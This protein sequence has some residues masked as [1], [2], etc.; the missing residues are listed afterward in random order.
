MQFLA[1]SGKP[2]RVA[3]ESNFRRSVFEKWGAQ[4]LNSI[5]D[6]SDRLQVAIPVNAKAPFRL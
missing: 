5:N 4:Q 3:A 6:I 1:N 2:I